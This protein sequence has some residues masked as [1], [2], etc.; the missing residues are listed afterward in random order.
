MRGDVGKEMREVGNGSKFGG[1]TFSPERKEHNGPKQKAVREQ[2]DVVGPMVKDFR[3][4]H[5]VNAQGKRYVSTRQP[6]K[7]GMDQENVGDVREHSE[8]KPNQTAMFDVFRG[9]LA[10]NKAKQCVRDGVQRIPTS[11]LGISSLMWSI[12]S[13]LLRSAHGPDLVQRI[14]SSPNQGILRLIPKN[15]FIRFII[16]HHGGE[17]SAHP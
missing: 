13:S 14:G 10:Q 3:V 1:S 6:T 5:E 7:V 4:V 11:C 12:N 17:P 9:H 2:P 8:P 15:S 16:V